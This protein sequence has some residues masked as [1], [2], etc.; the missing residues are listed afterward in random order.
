MKHLLL[1]HH[2]QSG[3]TAAMAQAVLDGA[4]DPAIA[5]VALRVASPLSADVEDLRWAN[6]VI[7]GT[8]ENFGYMSGALKYFFDRI[9]YPC[10]EE[11]QGLPYALFIKAGN[12]GS[13]ALASVRRIVT[14]LRWRE[15]QAPLIVIGDIN[16]GALADCRELGMALAAGLEAGLF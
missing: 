2:S 3:A 10:L 6:A 16:A 11:T 12:D 8:P 14:G 7:L 1:I 13:G 4:R 5:D 9:Y 15:V